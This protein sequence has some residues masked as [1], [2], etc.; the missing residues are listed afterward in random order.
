MDQSVLL[1]G[2]KTSGVARTLDANVDHIFVIDGTGIIRYEFSRADGFPALRPDDVRPT[3]DQA[4]AGS[5]PA[6]DTSFGAIKAL[7]RR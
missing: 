6:E 2:G 1:Y 7:Y 4:L 5:V 3:L